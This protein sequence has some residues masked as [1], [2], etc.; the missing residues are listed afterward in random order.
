VTPNCKWT[1]ITVHQVHTKILTVNEVVINHD[2]VPE[3]KFLTFS[4]RNVSELDNFRSL[5]LSEKFE[6]LSVI[7][8]N[9]DYYEKNA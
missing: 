4:A 5:T 3:R 7:Q 6:F 9:F 1:L 2:N 8:E